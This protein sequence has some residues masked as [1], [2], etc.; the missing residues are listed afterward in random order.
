[1]RIHFLRRLK[2]TMK[3][4]RVFDVFDKI[5]SDYKPVTF[6]PYPNYFEVNMKME[7]C[8]IICRGLLKVL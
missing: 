6:P 8:K 1:M 3:N 2:E 4:L 5:P 7:G